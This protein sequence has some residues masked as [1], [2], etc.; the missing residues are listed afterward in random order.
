MLNYYINHKVSEILEEPVNTMP[1]NFISL[2]NA[3]STPQINHR[4]LNLP[5]NFRRLEATNGFT[6]KGENIY[7]DQLTTANY[8]NASLYPVVGINTEYFIGRLQK[9]R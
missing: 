8:L 9:K 7:V 6:W 4:V 3:Q 1:H 2:F 5:G